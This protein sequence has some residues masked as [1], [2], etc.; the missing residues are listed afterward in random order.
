MRAFITESIKNESLRTLKKM[1]AIPSI[2]TQPDDVIAVPPFGKEIDRALKET[3]ALCENLGMETFCDPEGFYGFAEYGDGEETVGILCHVDVVPAGDG[4]AWES[5]PFKATERDGVLYGR[6]AQDAKGPAVVA[7][8]AFKAVLDQYEQ[9]DRKIRFIFG[10]DEETLWRCMKVYK[11]HEEIPDLGFVPDGTFPLT[12][13]EKELWQAKLVGPGAARFY[14]KCGGALNVV[15]DRA[16]YEGSEI[17]MLAERFDKLNV[18]YEKKDS[19]LIIFGKSAHASAANEG[20]NAINLLTKG[21][22]GFHPHPAVSFLAEKVDNET[23][24]FHLFGKVEDDR[25]GEIT[26]NVAS[27]VIN[28]LHSEISLDIRIP[29]EYEKELLVDKLKEAITPYGLDYQEYDSLPSLHVP[30][31]SELVQTLMNV[32]R[33]KTGDK[34]EPHMDGGATYARVMPNVV[35]FG[36]HFP[37]TPKLAHQVDEGIKL[38]DFY[39]AIDIYAEAIYQLCVEVEET[40]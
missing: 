40:K 18:K 28:N 3:L 14:I 17:D 27:L 26:F 13:S 37:D 23:N 35:A 22:V 11:Q 24:G 39:Q 33:D 32:Y 12:F 38:D 25:A 6:G 19:K 36:P 10:T 16:E 5:D 30:V 34:T 8:Y 15:P 31:D 20:E 21:L 9:F 2:N 4:S 1:I 29:A 7:L